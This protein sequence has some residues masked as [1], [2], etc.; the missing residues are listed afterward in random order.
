MPVVLGNWR[1]KPTFFPVIQAAIDRTTPPAAPL[2][3]RPASAPVT[4]AMY[5]P[6][7]SLSSVRL[8]KLVEAIAMAST[9]SG[10][11]FDPPKEVIVPAAWIT[12][13]TPSSS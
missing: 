9:T 1:T 2:T 3:T 6:T 5:S 12:G 13:L 8:T 10:L 7:F 11:G 4:S